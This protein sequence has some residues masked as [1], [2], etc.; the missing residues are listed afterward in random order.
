METMLLE[1]FIMEG[2]AF[3]PYY[4]PSYG[5]S[6]KFLFEDG[7]FR[8]S[9]VSSRTFLQ[10]IHRFFG[11][12]N[13]AMKQKLGREIGRKNLIPLPF[14]R[15]WTLVPF[16]VRKPIGN[17]PAYGWVLS[18]SILEMKEESRIRTTLLL[19][20]SHQLTVLQSFGSCQS[21][22]RNVKLVEYYFHDLHQKMDRIFER[23]LRIY[24][25]T[26][27]HQNSTDTEL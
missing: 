10:R 23:R 11:M 13:M 15:H 25:M 5:E 7:S 26:N 22:M 3:I 18:H 24:P 9:T 17:Q 6:T 8:V 14:S 1:D 2:V 12:D 27:R 20:G 16:K 21:Q 19:T 4:M